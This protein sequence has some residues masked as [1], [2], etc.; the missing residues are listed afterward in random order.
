[1]L[2]LVCLYWVIGVEEFIEGDA[3]AGADAIQGVHG[4][5]GAPLEDIA[6]GR[7]RNIGFFGQP[8]HGQAT[9][10]HQRF[11]SCFHVHTLTPFLS[12]RQIEHL[13]IGKYSL[14]EYFNIDTMRTEQY[15]CLWE[16]SARRV[17][18][19]NRQYIANIL[20]KTAKELTQVDEETVRSSFFHADRI[21]CGNFVE[22]VFYILRLKSGIDADYSDFALECKDFFGVK[23]DNIPENDVMRI[24]EKF[25]ELIDKDK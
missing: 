24:F 15:N 22:V 3:H 23:M 19:A 20:E 4:G 7:P 1:M 11:Q 17:D 5:V 14:T 25:E 13:K 6:Q 8:I 12:Y 18:N 9:L 10:R 16:R 2:G 21:R